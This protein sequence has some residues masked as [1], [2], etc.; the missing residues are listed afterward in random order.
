MSDIQL[1]TSHLGKT[2]KEKIQSAKSV[3]I[4][5][6]FS[7]KSGVRYLKNA[8]KLA[9]ELQADIKLLTGDYLHITQPEALKEL[10]SIDDRIEVRLWKSGG[11]SFHPKA[12]LIETSE[13][14]FLVVGSSNLSASA[15]TEGVE[16]SLAVQQNKELFEEVQEQFIH[17]FYHEK[18]ISVNNETIKEYESEYK[19][20][21]EKYPTLIRKWT[22]QEEIEAMLPEEDNKRKDIGQVHEPEAEYGTIKPRFAQIEALEELEKTYDEGY[23]KAMVVMAT[24]LGKTYLAAFF[25][26]K[27][28]RVLFIAH[29]EEILYQAEKSFKIVM[30]EASTGIYNGRTKDGEADFVFASVFTLSMKKHLEAFNPNS[31]DLIVI[32]EF[33]HAAADS[34]QRLLSYFHP[35]FLLG[36][37]AT[38]DRNDDRDVYALCEGNVAFKMDFLEAIQRNWLSPFQYFGVYDDTDYSQIRWLGN[39]YDEEQLLQAQLREDIAE[40]II[41]AWEKH[42]QTKS[43]VFCSSIRQAVFLS[44]YFNRQ[45]YNT[46]SLH[47]QQ[48]DISRKEAIRQL[49]AGTLEAIFTV[50]LFN[51]GID[52][53]SVDTILFVRP[54]E[55]LTVFTQQIGRGLRLHSSKDSCVI[56]DLIG[57]YRHADVK[58]S[59]FDQEL[60]GKRK[61]GEILPTVPES[62]AF[63]IDVKA[64]NLINELA[65]KQQPRKQQLLAAYREVKQELGRR[66]TYLELHLKGSI[67]AK[68]YYDEWKS[69]HAFLDWAD[70]LSEKEE[71][72]FLKHEEWFREVEK[73][74][75]QKSYK[76]VLLSAMLERGP[77]HWFDPIS[78]EEAATYFH[79]YLTSEEYRKR[80]DFSDKSSQKLWEYD[81]KKLANLIKKMPMTMWSGSSKGLITLEDNKFDVQVLPEEQEKNLL[82]QFTKEVC[83]YRLHYFF[84]R[85]ED[86][87][88]R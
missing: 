27:F 15:L 42:K 21:H 38:P 28:K 69:Y 24:G 10:M 78:P 65:H 85:R 16:W 83:Q 87:K 20:Y 67:G 18:T 56:I 26:E 66:P 30:P 31:F 60:D 45:G 88:N 40:N 70:E 71:E 80:I 77:E 75:M 50:D 32:D 46:V 23:K 74:G 41:S 54:T 39:R 7:M 25:A 63:E 6:S 64:I 47:S 8:L 29:R 11:V 59:V 72:V 2:I 51:E 19:E 17:L 14:E 44:D 61:K 76:M 12:Y 62:C 81:E 9:A 52:I 57:N 53:P 33:H 68:P 22:E 34:Y 5:T 58:L 49:E 36:I 1:I 84:Q 35:E 86:L 43:L 73:T 37:T 55:S 82:Y 79:D 13:G 3:Y 48:K 4:L